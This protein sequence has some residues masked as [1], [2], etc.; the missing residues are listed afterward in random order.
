MVAA[1]WEQRWGGGMRGTYRNRI[2]SDMNYMTLI[3]GV[4]AMIPRNSGPNLYQFDPPRICSCH[5][6]LAADPSVDMHFLPSA[7]V[8]SLVPPSLPCSSNCSKSND[9]GQQSKA[10]VSCSPELDRQFNLIN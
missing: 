6:L 9:A 8:A 4:D 5:F 1:W 3:L 7:S 10:T 2:C